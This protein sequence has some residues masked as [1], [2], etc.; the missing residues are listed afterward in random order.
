MSG[1]LPLSVGGIIANGRGRRPGTLLTL[2]AERGCGRVFLAP[3]LIFRM[4]EV[5]LR[6]TGIVTYIFGNRGRAPS[7]PL[8]EGL[9]YTHLKLS[10]L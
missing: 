6:A 2:A 7:S 3:S 1:L 4:A 5:L 10:I 8:G 9:L